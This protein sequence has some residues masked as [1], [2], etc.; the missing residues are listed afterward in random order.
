LRWTSSTASGGPAVAQ[1]ELFDKTS[2]MAEQLW[3]SGHEASLA[4]VVV[5]VHRKTALL[6]IR[7]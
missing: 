7:G 4:G 2:I 5:S 1:A 3:S 6:P